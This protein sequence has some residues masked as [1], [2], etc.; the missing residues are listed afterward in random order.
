MYKKPSIIA[1]FTTLAFIMLFFDSWIIFMIIVNGVMFCSLLLIITALSPCIIGNIYN[2]K[3]KE[4]ITKRIKIISSIYYPIFIALFFILMSLCLQNISGGSFNHDLEEY[5]FLLFYVVISGVISYFSYNLKINFN[6]ILMPILMTIITSYLFILTLNISNRLI[7]DMQF[8]FSVILATA[9]STQYNKKIIPVSSILFTS[10]LFIIF[11]AF[12]AIKESDIIWIIINFIIFWFASCFPL[13]KYTNLI[14]YIN[15]NLG[16]LYEYR[17][18][19][20]IKNSFILMSIIILFSVYIYLTHWF[21]LYS[22]VHII[23][24][25]LYFLPLFAVPTLLKLIYKEIPANSPK[26]IMQH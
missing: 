9:I 17:F 3:Y 23:L 8:P 25:A 1:L 19:S 15:Q 16:K 2:L 11:Y 5:L 4:P 7:M 18:K 20:K 6:F 13:I 21:F 22:V 10:I 24:T 12:S 26:E 14:C